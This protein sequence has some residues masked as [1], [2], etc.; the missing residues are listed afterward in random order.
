MRR[1]ARLSADERE[2]CRCGGDLPAARRVAA[3]DRAGRGSGQG[4]GAGHHRGPAGATFPPLELGDAR[5][6][7]A[8]AHTQAAIAWSYDLLEPHQQALLRCL[9]VFAGGWT[10]EAAEVVGSRCGVPEVLDALAVLVEQSLVV[11][12]DGRP[13]APLPPARDDPR[14]C[15]GAVGG[16]GGRGDRPRCSRALSAAPR[17]RERPGTTRCGRRHTAESPQGRGGQ[18]AHWHC[19]GP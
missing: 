1:A 14:V 15:G 7:T 17:A 8:S 4:P 12:D 13:R 10:L 5:R 2:R 16:R 3:G 6:A 11:R 19:V 18:P 9:A